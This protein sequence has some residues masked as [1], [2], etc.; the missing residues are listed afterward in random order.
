M[1]GWIR[2]D[3]SRADRSNSSC[4]PGL[5]IVSSQDN[6]PRQAYEV[7]VA[8][9]MTNHVHSSRCCPSRYG[10]RR[11][12]ATSCPCRWSLISMATGLAMS[13]RGMTMVASIVSQ[14]RNGISAV[15]F[16][17]KG[18]GSSARGRWPD[19]NRDAPWTSSSVPRITRLL[20]GRRTVT[21][22]GHLRRTGAIY[23]PAL[24]KDVNGDGVPDGSLGSDDGN[25][26]PST[27]ADGKQLWKYPHHRRVTVPW[28][29]RKSA[30]RRCCS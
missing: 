14:G 19:V 12:A 10:P 21:R 20:S 17:T 3:V 9:R 23:E 8:S 6:F 13:W 26:T 22:S 27:G 11:P 7:T 16:R 4:R 1:W 5:H 18:R 15:G 24:L 2:R 29:G 25:S 28:L 30:V